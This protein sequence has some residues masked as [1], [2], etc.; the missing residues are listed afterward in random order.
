MAGRPNPL[1]DKFVVVDLLKAFAEGQKITYFQA[2]RL[3]AL[4][5]LEK[6][7]IRR[8]EGERRGRPNLRYELTVKGRGLV[9]LSRNWKRKLPNG[10]YQ[11]A[12]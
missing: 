6:Q 5:Y 11:V 3:V 12:A 7:Y 1:N 2:E 4:G 8:V 9:N 10:E